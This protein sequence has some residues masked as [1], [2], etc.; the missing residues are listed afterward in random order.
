[1]CSSDLEEEKVKALLLPYEKTGDGFRIEVEDTKSATE[2]IV[3]N[4]ELFTDF[5]VVKGKMD[6]VFLAVTVKKGGEQ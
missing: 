2:L 4:P 3:K 1:M 5:E 6:D